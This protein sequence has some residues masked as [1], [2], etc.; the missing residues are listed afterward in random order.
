MFGF[1]VL[2]GS[3]SYGFHMEKQLVEKTKDISHILGP[4]FNL[5]VNAI[6]GGILWEDLKAENFQACY[7]V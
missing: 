7:P 3:Q 2:I 4:Y 6:Y 5:N 1:L